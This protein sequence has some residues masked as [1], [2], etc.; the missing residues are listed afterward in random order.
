MP[1]PS[2][3]ISINFRPASSTAIEMVCA[4]ASNEFSSNSLTTDAGRSM[5]SPAAICDA[6]S[7]DNKR[8]GMARLYPPFFTTF[9]TQKTGEYLYN[10][11]S[12]NMRFFRNGKAH[13]VTALGI[14]AP[15]DL[16]PSSSIST[17]HCTQTPPAYGKPS[18]SA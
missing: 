9:C 5:T 10:A 2:S 4:P 6:T 8:I 14:I 13:V 12:H 1:E 3:A 17:T 18:R 16:Q 11:H 15:C 7:E